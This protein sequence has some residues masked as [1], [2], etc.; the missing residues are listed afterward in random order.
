MPEF[1]VAYADALRALA[2]RIATLAGTSSAW[3]DDQLVGSIADVCAAGRRAGIARETVVEQVRSSVLFLRTEV[4]GTAERTALAE[5]A[6][7]AAQ[8][9]FPVEPRNS[10]QG[11]W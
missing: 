5:R 2:Q 11:R 3:T 6:A 1:T 4:L 10:P 8:R 9:C 7:A